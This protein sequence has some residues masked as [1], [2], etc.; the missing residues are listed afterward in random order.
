MQKSFWSQSFPL[1]L[2]ALAITLGFWFFASREENFGPTEN[3]L[4]SGSQAPVAIEMVV[5]PLDFE[6]GA[7]LM[8]APFV[9]GMDGEPESL[10]TASERMSKNRWDLSIE[11][12]SGRMEPVRITVTYLE[13]LSIEELEKKSGY[14]AET[15]SWGQLLI[16]DTRIYLASPVIRGGL[17]MEDVPDFVQFDF[18]KVDWALK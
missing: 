11:V 8:P 5:E 18:E 14:A 13:N 7:V 12:S 16:D 2:I 9:V 10:R 4:G 15:F 3:D 17:M 6:W 1:L